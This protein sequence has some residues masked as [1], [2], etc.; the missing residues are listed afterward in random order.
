MLRLT[1]NA[2]LHSQLLMGDETGS[3]GKNKSRNKCFGSYDY[4]G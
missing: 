3:L 1:R 4:E 2:S